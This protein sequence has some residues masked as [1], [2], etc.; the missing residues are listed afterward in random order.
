MDTG[1]TDQN[2]VIV[3]QVE[4]VNNWLVTNITMDTTDKHVTHRGAA[5]QGAA[6]TDGHLD[7]GHH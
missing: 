7:H 5:H 2:S 6:V 4:T 1:Q 3:T